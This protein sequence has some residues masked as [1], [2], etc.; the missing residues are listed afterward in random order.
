MG[1]NAKPLSQIKNKRVFV[2][3]NLHQDCWSVKSKETGRVVAHADSVQLDN[4]D[5]KVSEPGRQRVLR[6]KSKNVHAG[7]VGTLKHFTPK[8]SQMPGA[9]FV[10]EAPK[11]DFESSSEPVAITYN[12][13]K[14]AHFV[15]KA[16]EQPVA[17]A[18]TATLQA[19]RKVVAT[20]PTYLD[21]GI[22]AK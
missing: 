5:F 1:I 6:E 22:I 3:R 10:N 20:N 17:K 15:V 12:P 7:L 8:G 18:E 16:T 9:V 14:Y 13:Y 11:A 19:D 4:V 2:Y 21:E